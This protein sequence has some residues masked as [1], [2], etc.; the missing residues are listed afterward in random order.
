[1]A[2]KKTKHKFEIKYPNRPYLIY[3][4]KYN[5]LFVILPICFVMFFLKDNGWVYS[6]LLLIAWFVIAIHWSKVI[7]INDCQEKGLG[8]IYL[9]GEW[10]NKP[11][12]HD[13]HDDPVT[14]KSD[15][16]HFLYKYD[17]KRWYSHEEIKNQYEE[18]IK[19]AK[20]E[21]DVKLI[22]TT[23]RLLEEAYYDNVKR[24]F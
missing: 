4:V 16:L 23:L 6:I 1:M 8:N 12:P 2:G 10:I 15:E 9:D 13:F 24:G 18:E 17:E 21:F 14:H 3:P 11:K 22:K 7:W 20:D 19:N 5:E